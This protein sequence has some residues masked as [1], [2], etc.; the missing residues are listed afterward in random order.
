LDGLFDRILDKVVVP[1]VVKGLFGPD[2]RLDK[3]FKLVMAG[4]TDVPMG[5][6]EVVPVVDGL[7]NGFSAHITGN[8]LH[9]LLLLAMRFYD[10]LP[11]A[12]RKPIM[13]VYFNNERPVCRV[14][15]MDSRSVIR[16]LEK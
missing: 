4:F 11:A 7:L 3:E 16:I 5:D 2:R 1:F 15:R 10:G 14:G 13:M 6:V 9:I 8:G 12:G